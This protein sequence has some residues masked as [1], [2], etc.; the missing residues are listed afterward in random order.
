MPD[1]SRRN[2]AL[3][4]PLA[5]ISAAS[6]APL[7]QHSAVRSPRK[8]IHADQF[9]LKLPQIR[10]PAPAEYLNALGNLHGVA[11]RA[12]QRLIHVSDQRDD[13]L[14]HAP[15]GFH[16]QPGQ[17]FRGSAS[18]FMNAPEPVFTSSTSA[19][20]PSASFLLMMEAQISAMDSPPCRHVPQ[21]INF[22]VRGSDFRG[23]PDQPASAC[24][25]RLAKFRQ[26]KFTF[27]SRDGFQ[28][29]ERPA[30]MA[31]ARVR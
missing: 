13:S 15:P 18:F 7:P 2:F 22:L 9:E 10:R 5:I 3:A 30:G 19:S 29:V 20:I 1:A 23:L 4:R 31:Q 14:P 24:A 17:I 27:K 8:N 12:P 25:Q 26:R 16:H 6:V 11:R 28:F 21:R